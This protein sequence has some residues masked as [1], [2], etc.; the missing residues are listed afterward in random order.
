MSYSLA[1]NA[2]IALLSIVIGTGACAV[3]TPAPEGAPVPDPERFAADLQR[4]TT[5][6]TARQANFEWTLDEAG[7]RVRGRGVV[8]FVAPERQRL[9]L[10]GPRGETYLAAALVGEEFRIPAAAAQAVD[11]PSPS[12][13]WA[14]LGVIRPPVGAPLETATLA[15]STATLRYALDGGELLE[16]RATRSGDRTRLESVERRGSRGVLETLRLEYSASGDLSRARYR[17]LSAYRDLVFETESVRD[18]ESFPE[19]IWRPDVASR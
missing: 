17:D 10:F 9:D 19:T 1:K 14:A 13:L 6:T 4:A 7:S 15:D 16:Y 11:L 8:R 5:P 12:L 2:A 18:V 3:A